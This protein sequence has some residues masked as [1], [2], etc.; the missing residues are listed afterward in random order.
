M[1]YIL[2]WICWERLAGVIC[3]IIQARELLLSVEEMLLWMQ[4]VLQSVVM[5][6]KLRLFTVE[7]RWT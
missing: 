6:K 5:P 1:V 2:R 3:R 7:D 4:H